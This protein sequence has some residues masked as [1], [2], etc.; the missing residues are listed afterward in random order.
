MLLV[1]MNM[2]P[3]IATLTSRMAQIKCD[4]LTHHFGRDRELVSQTEKAGE[5]IPGLVRSLVGGAVVPIKI[6]V[7]GNATGF[8]RGVLNPNTLVLDAPV[9]KFKQTVAIMISEFR[10]PTIRVHG[11]SLGSGCPQSRQLH[12]IARFESQSNRYPC[13]Y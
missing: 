10:L 12:R 9:R 2:K 1:W 11:V 13:S 3:S 6:T 5:C 8:S 7:R 4:R